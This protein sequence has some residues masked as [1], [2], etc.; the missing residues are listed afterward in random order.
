[1]AKIQHVFLRIYHTLNEIS[2]KSDENCV[3]KMRYCVHNKFSSQVITVG[4]AQQCIMTS[5]TSAMFQDWEHLSNVIRQGI[6]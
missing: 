4:T 5:Y 3:K 6:H 2:E 1:M